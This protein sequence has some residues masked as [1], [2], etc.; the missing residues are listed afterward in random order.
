MGPIKCYK[1]D[2]LFVEGGFFVSRKKMRVYFWVN[3]GI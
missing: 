3:I 2:V 1:Q